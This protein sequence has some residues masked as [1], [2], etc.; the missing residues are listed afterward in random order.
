MNG[1]I[2]IIAVD[3][4]G[5]LE[6]SGKY[7]DCIVPCKPAFLVLKEF[8]E[9][10]GHVVLWTCRY[11]KALSKAIAFC[12]DNGLEFD[13]VNEEDP[14]ALESWLKTNPEPGSSKKIYADLYIDDKTPEASYNGSI[15]WNLIAAQILPVEGRRKAA[16]LLQLA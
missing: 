2:E 3:F 8:K 6:L 15:N 4:D 11:G 16:D 1:K 14:M 10:G 9:R 7:P 13:A 12:K 5:T